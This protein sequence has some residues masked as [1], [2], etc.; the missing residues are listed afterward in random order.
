MSILLKS[1]CWI[2]HKLVGW[3]VWA[4][5]KVLLHRIALH[6]CMASSLW[7]GDIISSLINLLYM[8]TCETIHLSDYKKSIIAEISEFCPVVGKERMGTLNKLLWPFASW[9]S[10]MPWCLGDSSLIIQAEQYDSWHF[11]DMKLVRLDS[12]YLLS[13]VVLEGIAMLGCSL[14]LGSTDVPVLLI[15]FRQQWKGLFT[16]VPATVWR[17]SFLG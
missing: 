12:T 15:S 13:E 3:S 9:V 16:P 6:M 11:L 7:W 8:K 14:Q 5:F 10:L 2:L 4:L 17:R 1:I